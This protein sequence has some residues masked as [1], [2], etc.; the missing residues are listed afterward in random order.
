MKVAT[1]RP[2][3]PRRKL[4]I[5]AV[6]HVVQQMQGL[7]DTNYGPDADDTTK[8][9]QGLV[10]QWHRMLQQAIVQEVTHE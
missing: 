3:K 1:F 4:P 5:E 8:A 9:F 10:R 2:L 7:I 6:E